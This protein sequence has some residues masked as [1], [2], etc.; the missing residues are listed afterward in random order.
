M[1]RLLLAQLF[2]HIEHLRQNYKLNPLETSI[3]T[4]FTA[5]MPSMVYEREI[6]GDSR[7]SDAV[8]PP[9]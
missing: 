1:F 7:D 2:E 4:G 9:P 3:C 6:T 5:T 8:F